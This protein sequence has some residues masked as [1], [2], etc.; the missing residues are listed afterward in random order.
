MKNKKYNSLFFSGFAFGIIGVI[1]KL[2]YRPL[3]LENNINDF[4]FSGFAPSLFATMSLCLLAAYFATKKPVITIMF[5]AI[6]VLAYEAEQIWTSR[7]F[8]YLDI[9]AVFLGFALSVL[10]YKKLTKK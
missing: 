5:V 3:V 6:G 8:D 7:V 10:F 1:S 4:G 9:A 2:V